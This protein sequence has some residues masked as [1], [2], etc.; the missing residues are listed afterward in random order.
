MSRKDAAYSFLKEMSK[1]VERRVPG[2][3]RYEMRKEKKELLKTPGALTA[4]KREL[5]KS[6]IRYH[7]DGKSVSGNRSSRK[8]DRLMAER[9]SKELRYL[10]E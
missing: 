5:E 4:R 3:L 1:S 9:R 8:G 10:N 6:A 2:T 7:S